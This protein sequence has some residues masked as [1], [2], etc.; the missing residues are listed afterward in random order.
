MLKI[1]FF[2]IFI[3][4]IVQAQEALN[5]ELVLKLARKSFD[6]SFKVQQSFRI[7]NIIH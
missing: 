7:S 4:L 2:G 1:I 3:N 6:S 5:L